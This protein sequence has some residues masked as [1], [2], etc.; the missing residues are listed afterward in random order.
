MSVVASSA[1][2][3]LPGSREIMHRL[4]AGHGTPYLALRMGVLAGL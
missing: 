3:Q 2:V 4:L 1:V